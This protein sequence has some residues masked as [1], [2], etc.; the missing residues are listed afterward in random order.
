MMKSHIFLTLSLLLSGAKGSWIWSVRHG[1][2][3]LGNTDRPRT[4]RTDK[5]DTVPQDAQY[6]E[7]PQSQS[8][9]ESRAPRT[10][11]AAN[12]SIVQ[13][14]T[15]QQSTQNAQNALDQI[16]FKYPTQFLTEPELDNVLPI[17]PGSKLVRKQYGPLVI[18]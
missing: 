8:V 14:Q 12:D 1:L 9:Q 6:R 4:S 15:S 13:A 10:S 16:L 11:P 2:K 7:I 18:R 17:A 3:E 5:S